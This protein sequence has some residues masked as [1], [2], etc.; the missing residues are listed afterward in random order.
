MKSPLSHSTHSLATL[1][2]PSITGKSSYKPT[3]LIVGA[4]LG[5]LM[6]GALLE[7][8]DIPYIIFERTSLIR[9][10]GNR[11]VHSTTPP[12]F[13]FEPPLLSNDALTNCIYIYQ[14]GSAISIGSPILALFQQL[15][16]YDELVHSCLRYNHIAAH[17]ENM[18][19]YPLQDFSPL[20]EL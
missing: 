17:K 4:G 14:I 20:E 9:P 11:F 15:G 3:V 1:H 16:I 6:L 10:L 7:K 5:G 2:A 8:I 19:P 18:E 12:S 13:I